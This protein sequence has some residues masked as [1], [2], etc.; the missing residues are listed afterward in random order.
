[1]ISALDAQLGI[2]VRQRLIE[3]KD[4][5]VANI[6]AAHG[7]AL[8]LTTRELRRLAREQRLQAENGG[9]FRHFPVDL[10]RLGAGQFQRK[11]HVLAALARARPPEK[12]A[13]RSAKDTPFGLALK[14][15]QQDEK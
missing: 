5:L 4:L 11:A 8:A 6:G 9:S 1:M 13:S 7:D 3:E 10:R 15:R 14:G 12:G 2:E